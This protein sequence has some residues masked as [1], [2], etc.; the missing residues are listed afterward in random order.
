M[1]FGDYNLTSRINLRDNQTYTGYDVVESLRVPDTKNKFFKIISEI[2]DLKDIEGGD[3]LISKDVQQHWPN[4]E[5][6]FF[7]QNILPKF[8]YAI[9]TS[10]YTGDKVR[11]DIQFGSWY[12][13]NIY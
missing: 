12:P 9:I 4:K 6:Q 1:G 11:Q 10:D 7:F 5:V 13:I 2:Y 3:L 8:K